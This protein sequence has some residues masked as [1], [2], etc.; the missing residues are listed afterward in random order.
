MNGLLAA[1][2]GLYCLVKEK[3]KKVVVALLK[4]LATYR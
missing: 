3:K 4:L 2:V 1:L